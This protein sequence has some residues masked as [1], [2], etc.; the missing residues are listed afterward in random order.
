MRFT[1]LLAPESS[2]LDFLNSRICALW[3]RFQS[4]R[5]GPRFWPDRGAGCRHGRAPQGRFAIIGCVAH[6]RMPLQKLDDLR[7]SKCL[8]F[9]E[10]LGKSFEILTFFGNDPYC[11]REAR[12]HQAAHFGVGF[13]R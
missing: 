10:T 8:I 13:L 12:F 6:R 3:L 11:V 1:P 5:L 7:T 2:S 9:E 4:A